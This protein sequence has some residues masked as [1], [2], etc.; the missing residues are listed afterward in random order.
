MVTRAA[1][2]VTMMVAP[3]VAAEVGL[4]TGLVWSSPPPPKAAQRQQGGLASE[5]RGNEEGNYGGGKGGEQ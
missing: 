2:A 4:R 3:T 5:G 1:K